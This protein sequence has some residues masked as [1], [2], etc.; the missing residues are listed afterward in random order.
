MSIVWESKLLRPEKMVL[1]AYADHADDT[2]GSVY[3]GHGR[4]AWKTG[5]SVRQVK[6]I[7]KTMIDLG[8]MSEIGFSELGTME[9]QIQLDDLPALPPYVGGKKKGRP[10]LERGDKMSPGDKKSSSGVTKSHQGGDTAMSS[11][12]SLDPSLKPSEGGDTKSAIIDLCKSNSIRLPQSDQEW[13]N[14]ADPAVVHWLTVVKFWPGYENLEFLIDEMGADIDPAALK[15][16]ARLWRGSGYSPKNVVGLLEWYWELKK[17]IEW[18]PSD[19]F[20][21]RSNVGSPAP[22]QITPIESFDG[23][24]G[25]Y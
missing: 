12:P 5:Y 15:E 13:A 19:R 21:K 14:M 22:I 9:Y 2:G 16:A 1:L 3:P 18:K 24:G 23:G 8:Y 25:T 11:D 7:T 6:R 10:G 4:V 20:K 17:N